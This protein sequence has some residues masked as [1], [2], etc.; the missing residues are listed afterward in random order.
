MQYEE[1]LR[2]IQQTLVELATSPGADTGRIVEDLL[3]LR[4][5]VEL[6][7]VALRSELEDPGE[8]PNEAP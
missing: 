3:V 8:T 1:R 4:Q 5:E 2:L 6:Q 7:I